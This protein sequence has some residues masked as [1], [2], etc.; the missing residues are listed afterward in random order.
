ME[1][2]GRSHALSTDVLTLTAS[3]FKSETSIEV[4]GTGEEPPPP[5]EDTSHH[6]RA[7]L[8]P[9]GGAALLKRGLVERRRASTSD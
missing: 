1:A 3:M 7:A 8:E 4:V 6:T 2:L 9:N 5:P